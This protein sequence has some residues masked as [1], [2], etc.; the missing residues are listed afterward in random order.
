MG[1]C[2]TRH[3]LVAPLPQKTSAFLSGEIAM[4]MAAKRKQQSYMLML[5]KPAVITERSWNHDHR[6]TIFII[7]GYETWW[8]K[9]TLLV[10]SLWIRFK[11]SVKKKVYSTS[12]HECSRSPWAYSCGHTHQ[13]SQDRISERGIAIFNICNK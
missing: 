13:W 7:S 6:V 3:P 4:T 11:Y 9:Q 1:R 5:Y 8:S 10:H 2:T 12:V